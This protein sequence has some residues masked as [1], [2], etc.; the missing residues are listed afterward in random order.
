MPRVWS[1]RSACAPGEVSP[2]VGGQDLGL[3]GQ[4]SNFPFS[5]SEAQ[6]GPQTF[7][8]IKADAQTP[9]EVGPSEACEFPFH[10]SALTPC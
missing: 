6:D 10:L 2:T 3:R 1:L 7:R 9:E 4:R 8:V 5:F